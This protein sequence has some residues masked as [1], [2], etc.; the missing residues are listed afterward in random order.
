MKEAVF[1]RK[2]QEEIN[3]LQKKLDDKTKYL[4]EI[5]ETVAKSVAN[6]RE[7]TV[8][9]DRILL[10]LTYREIGKKHGTTSERIRQIEEKIIRKIK[11]SS[12][13]SEIKY[14]ERCR[15][16]MYSEDVM[17]EK[18]KLPLRVVNTLKENGVSN[19]VGEIIKY[20]DEEL[21]EFVGMGKC[22]IKEIKKGLGK[23]G[24]VLI[25]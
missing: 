21:I 11:E 10:N 17:F 12:T 6:I 9:N 15:K 24:L 25:N 23:L 1:I 14:C 22:G 7:L 18:M 20:T 16:K 3:K 19:I 2:Q 4:F 13:K 8:L 5:I